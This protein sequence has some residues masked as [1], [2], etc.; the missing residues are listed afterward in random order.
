MKRNRELPALLM[1]VVTLLA[2]VASPADEDSVSKVMGSISVS[3]GEHAGNL[4]TVNGS[5]DVGDNA[6]VGH[7][8]TVNG[9]IRLGERATA[10]ELETV[11]GSV[12]LHQGARVT[13]SIR[14]VNGS[15]SLD[16]D[17]DVGERLGN[18]NG[19]IHVRGAHV[20]GDID[21]VTGSI[22]LGPDARVDGGIHVHKDNSSDSSSHEPPR[23]VILPG[24]TVKGTLRFERPVQLFVSDRAT[25]GAVEGA[26]PVKFS[27]DRPPEK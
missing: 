26:T 12:K 8:R 18:V 22:E 23:I 19:S 9:S 25:I 7:A 24:S 27:G 20:G 1:L 4:G 15:L 3:A 21:T 11:N 10:S 5:I 17:A 13:G 16:Q 2:W 6:V 14:T